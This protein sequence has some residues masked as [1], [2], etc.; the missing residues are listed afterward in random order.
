MRK[1]KGNALIFT[2]LSCI[3]VAIVLL[4]GLLVGCLLLYQKRIQAS[5]EELALRAACSLNRSDRVGQMNVAVE[6]SR[7][8][9]FTARTVNNTITSKYPHLASLSKLMLDDA[10]C[11]AVTVEESRQ[12]L[13]RYLHEEIRSTVE[14]SNKQSSLTNLSWLGAPPAI[15]NVEIGFIEGIQSNA[16]IPEGI[17]ELR[18][19]DLARGLAQPQSGLYLANQDARLPDEDNDLAFKFSSLPAPVLKTVSPSRLTSNN[20]FASRARVM[21]SGTWKGNSW[22]QI[23]SAV[24]LG[25]EANIS[26]AIDLKKQS[27]EGSRK[28]LIVTSATTAG[29]SQV[30]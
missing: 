15:K 2:M 26:T 12:A 14:A 22:D 23:P 24:R 20:A 4:V 30:K 17:P 27:R 25:V 7:E 3:I 10:R 8:L 5:T 9:V 28:M 21:D 19:F 13:A 29:S 1:Q 11:G 18:D 6:H 16:Q